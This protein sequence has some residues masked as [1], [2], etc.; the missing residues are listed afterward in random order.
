MDE[1]RSKSFVV[2]YDDRICTHAANCVRSLPAVFDISRTP[3][4]DVSAS[5][6]DTIERQVAE[7]P[8]GALSFERVEGRTTP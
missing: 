8:S 6:G 7:C 4:I 1:Y 2:R 5:D 3:W